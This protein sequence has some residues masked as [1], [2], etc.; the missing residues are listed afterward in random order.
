ME[1]RI[2]ISY[3]FIM[4][5]IARIE[6]TYDSS[7]YS[8]REVQ[9]SLRDEARALREEVIQLGRTPA[10]HTVK[11]PALQYSASQVKRLDQDRKL[12]TSPTGNPTPSQ[13]ISTADKKDKRHLLRSSN[14]RSS[15]RNMAR[16][17]RR[18]PRRTSSLITDDDSKD[19]DSDGSLSDK[20]D[21]QS[22]TI[23]FYQRL[24]GPKHHRIDNL[25]PSDESFNR[26]VSY[27]Y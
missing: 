9:E 26:L 6:Q 1:R 7:H 15:S 20:E 11:H 18:N 21:P 8:S 3:D 10:R 2:R 24:K 12:P 25:F 23:S 4:Y 14:S 16:S 17:E 27:H 5:R 13:R 19:T 22:L